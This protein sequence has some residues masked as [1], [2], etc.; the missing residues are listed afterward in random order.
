MSSVLISVQ[1]NLSEIIAEGE[2]MGPDRKKCVYCR[3]AEYTEEPFKVLVH[4]RRVV[5]VQFYFCPFCGRNLR[6]KDN[7]LTE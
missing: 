2:K 7:E 6:S 5:E 1:S 3:Y 4:S